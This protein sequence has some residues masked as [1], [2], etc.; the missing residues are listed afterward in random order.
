M[1]AQSLGKHKLSASDTPK[2]TKSKQRKL[3]AAE[4]AE[5][6]WVRPNDPNLKFDFIPADKEEE[7][8]EEKADSDEIEMIGCSHLYD[9]FFTSGLD[10]CS[11]AS[12][13]SQIE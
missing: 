6:A 4:Q 2:S 12:D 5:V 13:L 11:L 9:P 8:E 3:S 10:D 7:E 1:K